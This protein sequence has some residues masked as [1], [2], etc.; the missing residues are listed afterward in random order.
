MPETKVPAL[1]D[2]NTI[3]D[4]HLRRVLAAVKEALDIRLGR[5]GDPLDRGLT[6]R[7]LYENG[8]I[9]L[10]G[11]PT[12]DYNGKPM[13]PSLGKPQPIHPTPPRNFKAVVV[14]QT[15][16]MEWDRPGYMGHSMTE[17][18]RSTEDDL[19][20]AVLVGTSNALVAS[21]FVEYAPNLT[22]YYWIRF[23]SQTGHT[24]PYNGTAGTPIT[25]E[26]PV[27]FLLKELEGAIT[28]SELHETLTSRINLIDAP[29]NV[30]NSVSARIFEEALERIQQIN[31]ERDARETEIVRLDNLL[32]SEAESRA[33]SFTQ[34]S[35]A[36]GDTNSQLS[37]L[38]S[39]VSTNQ[40]TTN[41]AITNLQSQI[42]DTVANTSFN[43][44]AISGLTTR[45]TNNEN[46]ISIQAGQITDI[47][48]TLRNLPGGR[49]VNMMVQPYS[50]F[51]VPN[52]EFEIWRQAGTT[53]E[54][55]TVRKQF[56]DR[57][58]RVTGTSTTNAVHLAAGAADYNVVIMPDRG[59]I[60]SAY[61]YVEQSTTV[62]LRV[63][64]N[65]GS[66]TTAVSQLVS[67]GSWQRIHGLA[68]LRNTT[69]ESLL[70]RLEVDGA[71]NIAFFDGIMLEQWYGN[72]NME[73][74]AYVRPS[75][76]RAT[77][78]ALQQLTTRVT[79]NEGEI[80][81]IA[82][83]VTSLTTTV[84]SNTSTISQQAQSIDG[85]RAQYT[86]RIDNN[87]RVAGY[88]LA[89]GA[90]GVSDF[91]VL[92]DRFSIFHPSASQSLVFGVEGGRTIISGAYIQNAS[93][94]SAKIQSLDAA[95]INTNSLAA[96][97]ANLG[98]VTAGRLRSPDGL[99]DI[100]LTEG[101][102][103]IRSGASG[104]R[105]DIEKDRISVYDQNGRLRVR[106]GRL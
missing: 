74:S 52:E 20:T 64:R 73:P 59:W 14:F 19:S 86:V 104:A 9:S 97:S 37:S 40:Q 41:T 81:S 46:D 70:V 95:K 92:A 56:Y 83:N 32:R 7:D 15:V 103:R 105:L 31:D 93:I 94:D 35:S 1:P 44:G 87:G 99:T 106:I 2:P 58:L 28:A 27:S 8:V 68:D 61:V 25:P 102:F 78:Q 12:I 69:N 75:D 71:G 96:I 18:W 98:T 60:L 101:T 50:D 6:V 36:L 24:G 88:G 4:P 91:S 17:I 51:E 54:I 33:E 39:T 63:R 11:K 67:A 5:R 3:K 48:S 84:G 26:P 66:Y 79:Q 53:A 29:A 10:S 57:A 89:S 80:H 62:R 49:G 100:N 90:G 38:T 21:D 47:N 85:L 76:T 34:L 23:V 43:A 82:T 13:Q 65:N 16:L 45:V 55:S 22:Y 42:N 30:A 72:E 77:S